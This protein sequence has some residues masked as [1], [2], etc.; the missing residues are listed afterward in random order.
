[1]TNAGFEQDSPVGPDDRA[2]PYQEGANDPN[3][4]QGDERM[5]AW[6][7]TAPRAGGADRPFETW[8]TGFDSIP[9]PSGT[10]QY[11]EMNVDAPDRIFQTVCLTTGDDVRWSFFHRGRSETDSLIVGAFAAGSLTPSF[12]DPAILVQKFTSASTAPGA[13]KH[14][15]G[16]STFVGPTGSYE[17]GWEGAPKTANPGSG[18]LLDNASAALSPLVEI[19]SATPGAIASGE[20]PLPL[21]LQIAGRLTT[22]GRMTV[23]LHGAGLDP[24]SIGVG[25][26]A[27][28]PGA[29]ATIDHHGVI[30]VTIP[31]GIYG[32]PSTLGALTV[33]VRLAEPS[34]RHVRLVLAATGGGDGGLGLRIGPAESCS[35][36]G[37]AAMTVTL[38]PRPA[39][40][41][42]RA[43]SD[44][45]RDGADAASYVIENLGPNTA[46]GVSATLGIPAGV[47]F[48]AA[49]STLGSCGH[50]ESRVVCHFGRLA[51]GETIAVT[52][53]GSV[54]S[55]AAVLH[56]AAHVVSA[57]VDD[58]N[59][60]N[61][62]VVLRTT[63]A[64]SVPPAPANE[65]TP[66]N[67]STPAPP[68]A[69]PSSAAADLDV[70]VHAPRVID[71]LQPLHFSITVANAGPQ[72]APDTKVTFTTPRALDVQISAPRGTKCAVAGTT[73]C[74]LG[75]LAV[76]GR[77][78]IK[79]TARPTR[80]R[81]YAVLAVAV[82]NGRDRRPRNNVDAAR[83][84]VGRA[85]VP[86][87]SRRAA[88]ARA[89][90][91]C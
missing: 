43:T 47:T 7:T 45:V 86:C 41:A 66:S 59:I 6:S 90:I 5:A 89:H 68:P 36:T 78:R 85:N 91:A 70:D 81:T 67:Q 21:R 17:I 44:A 23:T 39:D 3:P 20:S 50:Q 29:R 77:A 57:T 18:N 87:G 63:V 31:H 75:Q 40:L 27:G 61:N 16:T 15:E 73:T 2:F 80:L 28:I 53:M 22:T 56:S 83:T 62:F 24:A 60:D 52:V 88:G 71:E 11:I 72:A 33:P 58:T 1:M 4:V 42:I 74:E 9:S 51:R 25:D 79:V 54:T 32:P 10:G 30:T 49:D 35:G 65:P 37:T 13:W 26:P 38:S 82:T 69:P 48:A 34:E 46:S 8:G 19:S 84:R 64:D 55:D 14:Y 12:D 76:G